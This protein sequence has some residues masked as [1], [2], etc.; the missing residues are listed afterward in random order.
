MV[1]EDAFD[2]L[3]VYL[4]SIETKFAA[5]PDYKE[6]SGDIEDAIAE[7]FRVR[8]KNKN[9]VVTKTDVDEVVVE[10]GTAEE[11]S[12]EDDVVMGKESAQAKDETSQST[13][14]TETSP[15][16]RLYRDID[17]GIIAGVSAG[18]AKYFDIDPVIVRVIFVVSVLFNGFGIIAYIVLWL[19]IPAARTTADKYA[20][21]G[22][23]MTVADITER[24][25]KNLSDEENVERA[26]GAWG[27]IRNFLT[28]FFDLLGKFLRAILHFL[29]YG[30]G[31]VLILLATVGIVALVSVTSVFW[32]PDSNFV[33]AEIQQVVDVFMEESVSVPFVLAS[34][35]TVFIPL[36]VLIVFGASLFAGRNFFTVPKSIA[37][38]VIWIVAFTLVSLFGINY[39]PQFV[40]QLQKANPEL[41]E[42]EY[43]HVEMEWDKD[44]KTLKV[45][46]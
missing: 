18:L 12:E 35:V 13:S 23:R 16:R 10:L 46:K 7:K 3:T 6:I 15:K 11:V 41:F 24:V 20:M 19:L 4:K 17:D 27:S 1:E 8:G 43:S 9:K 5:S 33:D 29:R 42:E 38:F 44:Q 28:E 22:E 32:M 31:I 34:A 37:L 21:R 14:S 30:V 40:E 25:K 45:V 2:A 36:I 26:K 39:G